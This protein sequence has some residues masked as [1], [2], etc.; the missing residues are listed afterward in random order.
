M[1]ELVKNA[2]DVRQVKES[3]QK[4][5]IRSMQDKDALNWMLGHRLGRRLYWKWMGQ[6][7][8]FETSYTGDNNRTNFNEGKRQIGLKMLSELNAVKPEAYLQMVREAEEDN[9]KY[10]SKGKDKPNE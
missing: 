1:D 8:V 10:T 7:G 6:T 5:K 9:V 4:E 3:K 2:A